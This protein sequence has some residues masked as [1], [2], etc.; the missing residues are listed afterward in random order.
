MEEEVQVLTAPGLYG[1]GPL[2]WQTI[3]ENLPGFK[4]IEQTDWD[5]PV[6]TDWISKIETAVAEAGPD[7]VIAAHS[8]GCL[9]LA[10]WAQHTKLRIRGAL[11]VAPPDA[12]RAGFPTV[13]QSFAPVPL[14]PLPFKSIV[15]SSTNDEYAT[16]QRSQT[17]ANAWGSRFVNMG[18]AGH[19]NSDSNLGEWHNG[20]WLVEELVRNW[21]TL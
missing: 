21:E 17:F 1:S 6:L 2:H 19:I 18:E 4:R 15:V 9:A 3:W 11:L 10:H 13:A 12:D 8:L 5:H 7:V 16:L 20:Q 14:Q